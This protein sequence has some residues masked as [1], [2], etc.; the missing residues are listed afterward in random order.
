M[1]RLGLIPADAT[2]TSLARSNRPAASNRPY[3]SV[4]RCG[5]FI[6][7]PLR[8]RSL[9]IEH[10][11]LAVSVRGPCPRCHHETE[12]GHPLYR[13]DGFL[14]LRR[15]SAAYRQHLQDLV[16]YLRAGD[17]ALRG[18]HEHFDHL[19]AAPRDVSGDDTPDMTVGQLADA[20]IDEII[21]ENR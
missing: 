1:R 6:S 17:L 5:S 13:S 2:G 19:R 7:T 3:R 12:D 15:G 14:A 9:S 4:W 11:A 16:Q 8:M 10:Y 18:E 20:W 21:I